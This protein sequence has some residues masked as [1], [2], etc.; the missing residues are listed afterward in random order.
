MG[1]SEAGHYRYQAPMLA[2]AR[3]RSEA[4]K[5]QLRELPYCSN[6]PSEHGCKGAKPLDAERQAQLERVRFLRLDWGVWLIFSGDPP[7]VP[8]LWAGFLKLTSFLQYASCKG[9]EDYE[10]GKKDR[11]TVFHRM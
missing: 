7:Y 10:G 6:N 3:P 4:D 11:C 8:A 2:G 9:A 1:H 5:S